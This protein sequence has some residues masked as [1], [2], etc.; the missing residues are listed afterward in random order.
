MRSP[1]DARNI[2]ID[3][4]NQCPNRCSNCTRLCGHHKEPFFMDFETFKRAVDSLED[5]NG[6]IGIIG[7]EPTIHPEFERFAGYLSE[8]R[9]RKQVDVLRRPTNEFQKYMRHHMS[10]KRGDAKAGLW[11]SL[12]YGY[13]KHMEVINEVFEKQLLNDHNNA[14]LHQAALMPYR[15]LGIDETK[16]IE[17]RDKCW[18][19]NTWS[20]CI[21][22][23]GAF[24]CEV[25]GALDITFGGP[26]GW[27]IEKGWYD[28]APSEFGE[29]LKWCEM[30]SLCLNVPQR[31]STDGRDD[32]TPGTYK[33]LLRIE[34]PKALQGKVVVH[35][36][37]D[38]KE[39]QYHTFTGKNDYMDA[40]D[41]KRFDQSRSNINPKRFYVVDI[42]QEKIEKNSVGGGID[43]VIVS[44]D[45]K[46]A[47][48]AAETLK[49]Y[50]LNPGC[51]YIYK[52]MLIFNVLAKAVRDDW[53]TLG[54]LCLTDLRSRYPAGKV[55]R[56]NLFDLS[57]V[58]W[59]YKMDLKTSIK[60]RLSRI[61]NKQ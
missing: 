28:R 5:W 13:Y 26:G 10:D 31:I 22:P 40:G 15:E 51:L 42:R 47:L 43:W 24:F 29:Q 30:C 44:S 1:K 61:M 53:N 12:N 58:S 8:K 21:T 6:V 16:F 25:A 20:P 23:K 11:S 32:V 19:Q 14:C 55:I 45:Q 27:K 35:D 3:I 39:E 52:N 34:S 48:K 2:Q 54:S 46:K 36:P 60:I 9:V 18:I 4:T 37:R 59:I 41:N 56:I 33:E 38:Y 17:M 7:G 57:R 49:Q 50:I